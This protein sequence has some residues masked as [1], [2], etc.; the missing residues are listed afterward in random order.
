MPL[1][2]STKRGH[3]CLM[4]TPRAT[5]VTAF[6]T[7]DETGTNSF[8]YKTETLHATNSF[9]CSDA[10][11][12]TAMIYLLPK[13]CFWLSYSWYD[14]VSKFVET[15]HICIG[16]NVIFLQ[17]YQIQK[18]HYAGDDA[19]GFKLMISPNVA[20]KV[21]AWQIF[22]QNFYLTQLYSIHT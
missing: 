11:E 15:M 10:G 13:R 22:L 8:W 12:L 4:K 9:V 21:P 20:N 1:L 6:W 14:M 18:C 16:I 7:G 3:F 2:H 5:R 17:D 19:C